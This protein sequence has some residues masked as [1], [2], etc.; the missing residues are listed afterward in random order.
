MT[1]IATPV[2]ILP[3][4]IALTSA[5]LAA[6]APSGDPGRV[7]STAPVVGGDVAGAGNKMDQTYREIYMPG[8]WWDEGGSLMSGKGEAGKTKPI[9]GE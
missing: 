6:C 7:T 5:G 8:K 1:R 3:F 2:R 4:F 9:F